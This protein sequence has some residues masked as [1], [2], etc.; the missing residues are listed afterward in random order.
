MPLATSDPCMPIPGLVKEPPTPD[1]SD[2]AKAIPDNDPFGHAYDELFNHLLLLI[3]DSPGAWASWDPA[4]KR[5]LFHPKIVESIQGAHAV[6]WVVYEQ[7]L[8][9]INDL[10]GDDDSTKSRIIAE[11]NRLSS[12]RVGPRIGNQDT[13]TACK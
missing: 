9:Q 5:E 7:F 2:P 8:R 1:P 6:A 3:N 11:R 13:T 10:D 12:H 4:E